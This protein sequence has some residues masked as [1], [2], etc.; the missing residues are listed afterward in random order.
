M[1]QAAVEVRCRL[2]ADCRLHHLEDDVM[3]LWARGREGEERE[4]GHL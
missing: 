2:F 4:Q 1:S 3:F